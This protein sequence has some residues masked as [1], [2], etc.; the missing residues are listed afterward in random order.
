MSESSTPVE[1]PLEALRAALVRT[2][3]SNVDGTPVAILPDGEVRDL[4]HLL[5]RPDSIQRCIHA[6]RIEGFV[7]YVN[8]F[9]HP[10]TKIYSMAAEDARVEARIDDHCAPE[11]G[12]DCSWVRHKAVFGCPTTP[13]WKAWQSMDRQRCNQVEFAEFLENNLGDI[14][15]PVAADLMTAVLEFQDSS[16]VEFKS[17]AR[18]ADGRVQF[19]YAE[20]DEGGE[21]KF[22]DRLEIGVPVFEG[23]GFRY[24]V[25]ARI[26]Y[27]MREGNLSIWYELHKPDHVLRKAYEDVLE[28]VERET[29]IY[30]HRAH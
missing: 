4:R 27:R 12:D 18:L 6:H 21:I 2:E 29:T 24:K 16:R 10:S 26:R 17:H 3:L 14:T 8:Q 11:E 19:T 1:L 15:E 28:H 25:S 22:P 30:V 13:E 23:M 9:K 5:S 20:K 7:S